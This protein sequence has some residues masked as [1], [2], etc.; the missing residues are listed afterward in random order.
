[1]LADISGWKSSD[2]SGGPAL[3]LPLLSKPNRLLLCSF[4]AVE[5]L[6]MRLGEARDMPNPGSSL[7]PEKPR[8][9]HIFGRYDDCRRLKVSTLG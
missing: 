8:T 6:F 4:F 9:P 7:M 5:F 2:V 3:T 1:M